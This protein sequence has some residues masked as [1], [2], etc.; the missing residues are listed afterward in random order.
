MEGNG[1]DTLR[2]AAESAAILEHAPGNAAARR[3]R[4]ENVLWALRRHPVEAVAAAARISVAEVGEILDREAEAQAAP[5]R[6]ASALRFAR[7]AREQ[8]DDGGGLSAA[9]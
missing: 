7:G 4:D 6:Q 9:G 8:P 3:R 5:D 2:I 1:L